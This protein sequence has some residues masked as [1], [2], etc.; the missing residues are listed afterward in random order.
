MRGWKNV[1]VASVLIAALSVGWAKWTANH[2]APGSHSVDLAPVGPIVL[3][4]VALLV[5]WI[6][7]FVRWYVDTLR[8]T[9]RDA[10][11]RPDR[12]RSHW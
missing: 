3:G 4:I 9:R 2:P 7:S 12:V 8:R 10:E 5:L 1:A 6:A 11:E